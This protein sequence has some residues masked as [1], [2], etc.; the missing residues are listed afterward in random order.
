MLILATEKKYW[1]TK[2]FIKLQNEWYDKLTKNGFRDLEW[3]D[4]KTGQGHSTPFLKDSLSVFKHLYDAEVQNHFENC[5]AYLAHGK[6]PT[7][8]HKFI[9][10]LYCDGVSYRKM[11]PK[12]KARRFKK[13]PSIFWISVEINK[14]R[15]SM[16]RF[17]LE[18]PDEASE[19][20]TS[21]HKFI[22]ANDSINS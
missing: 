6:F 3:L 13:Q 12:I 15:L 10:K 20:L 16:A 22:E 17:I 21:L 7:R 14:L 4:K 1:H 19:D 11:L 2:E 8:L 5:R 18:Q 9:W